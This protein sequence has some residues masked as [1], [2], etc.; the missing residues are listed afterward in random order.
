MSELKEVQRCNIV[1]CA[2]DLEVDLRGSAERTSG[3]YPKRR[4]SATQKKTD[5]KMEDE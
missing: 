5:K 3:S 2:T 4:N 1:A